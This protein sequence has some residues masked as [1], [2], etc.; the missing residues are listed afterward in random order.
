MAVS[1]ADPGQTG[2][3]PCGGRARV[4]A[5]PR[6]AGFLLAEVLVALVLL[7]VGISGAF[8]LLVHASRTM[9][10]ADRLSHSVP[11]VAALAEGG[12]VDP[13]GT[14]EVPVGDGSPVRVDW[15][16][17]EGALAVHHHFHGDSAPVGR[18]IPIPWLEDR[19]VPN[20]HD[21]SWESGG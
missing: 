15:W 9:H 19:G 16:W 21:P 13:D 8:L 10:R 4:H 2:F 5:D 11:F 18:R 3:L 7:G 6:R 12:P 17:E 20:L 1:G 14:V